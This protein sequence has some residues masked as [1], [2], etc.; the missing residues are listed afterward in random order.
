LSKTADSANILQ[1]SPKSASQVIIYCLQRAARTVFRNSIPKFNTTLWR[2]SVISQKVAYDIQ[3][4]LSARPKPFGCSGNS[5]FKAT[6]QNPFISAE[7]KQTGKSIIAASLVVQSNDIL[8]RMLKQ[9]AKYR[10][11][12]IGSGCVLHEEM[13]FDLGILGT[14]KLVGTFWVTL[15][16]QNHVTCKGK[17]LKPIILRCAPRLDKFFSA[18]FTDIETY[19]SIKFWNQ[20]AVVIKHQAQNQHCQCRDVQDAIRVMH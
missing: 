13:T 15:C 3:L 20:R 11:C 16:I 10:F 14:L 19:T 6:P 8:P 18:V 4:R 1:T 17:I 7:I 5:V 12:V 9:K 2:T